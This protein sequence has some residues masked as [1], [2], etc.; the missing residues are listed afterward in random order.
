MRWFKI[1]NVTISSSGKYLLHKYDAV[2]A[3]SVRRNESTYVNADGSIFSDVNFE[4]RVFQIDGHI[5]AESERE[6]NRLKHQLIQELNPKKEFEIKYFDGEKIYKAN[7]ISDSLPDFGE[8]IK[9]VLPLSIYI[10]IYGFYW[11]GNENRS[12]Y[13]FR[14]TDNI[15]GTFELPMIIST[16][17]NKTNI[18]NG[19]E[20]ESFPTFIIQCQESGSNVEISIQNQTTH[21]ELKII[22]DITTGESITVD[23]E[24]CKVTSNLDGNIIQLIS[25]D[26][27]FFEL[28]PKLNQI[29]VLC[30]KSIVAK[31][32]F[33]ERYLGV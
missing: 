21:K 19:G 4:P 11:N 27:D 10:N 5:M 16:K 12:E 1:G 30:A 18:Y 8:R 7:A 23:M 15:H 3:G 29:E 32:T 24:K 2:S 9:W 13:V 17:M 31:C 28:V 20:V 26:S 22:K 6:M 25:I 14:L 33:S